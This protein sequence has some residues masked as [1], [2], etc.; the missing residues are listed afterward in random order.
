HVAN[1]WLLKLDNCC[2]TCRI[3]RLLEQALKRWT[4]APRSLIRSVAKLDTDCTVAWQQGRPGPFMQLPVSAPQASVN[5]GS[6]YNGPPP[7][8]MV[9]SATP[10]GHLI[11][12]PGHTPPQ[13]GQP[14]PSPCVPAGMHLPP[15]H[16]GP[17]G[18]PPSFNLDYKIFEMNRRLQQRSDDPDNAS[19]WW[20]AFASEF[21]EDDA[22][23]S[24]SFCLEDGPKRYT[25]GRNLI[26]RYF[27][28][29]FEGGVIEL[30]YI[31]RC[32]RETF[33][34]PSNAVILDC[35]HT[36]MVTQHCKP[37]M[38]SV[39]TD[40]RLLCEFAFSPV[41]GHVVDDFIPRIRTWHFLIRTHNEYI[42]RCILSPEPGFLEQLSKNFT[43][44]GLTNVTLNY[45]RLC[46]ILEPMQELMALQKSCSISPRDCLKSFMFQKWQAHNVVQQHKFPGGPPAAISQPM[47]PPEDAPRPTSK[48]RKRKGSS[49]GANAASGGGK[50][51]TAASPA[52]ASAN[53]PVTTHVDV[54][55]VSEPSM[56]GGE[57]GD[58]DER[59]ISRLENTQ[60]DPS[61]SAT[62]SSMPAPV[63]MGSVSS[64]QEHPGALAAKN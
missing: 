23:L 2:R 12:G 35:E 25:I 43:R 14:G 17:R 3:V 19:L 41:P 37:F 53:F 61:T 51:K 38:T 21:F 8:V 9:Q 40:G 42:P 22:T 10:S 6:G 54:M 32:T 44:Q 18:L 24:L 47:M 64:A 28:S 56:M 46:V 62:P 57:F 34:Q 5:P 36:S 63:P 33:H 52:P 4:V 55:V 16:G 29:I 26:P 13:L 50:K 1:Q 20:D 31:T 45:L 58:E 60:F 39:Q 15:E 48:R 59:L 30:Y 49:G 11:A 7:N 27:R